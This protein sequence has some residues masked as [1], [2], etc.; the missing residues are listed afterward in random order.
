MAY[1]AAYVNGE[2][3]INTTTVE[4]YARIDE[5]NANRITELN[6]QKEDEE[7]LRKHREM[8]SKKMATSMENF[9]KHL[10]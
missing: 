2:C 3:L 7:N 10:Q 6:N 9:N 1:N 5:A 4:D 8:Q